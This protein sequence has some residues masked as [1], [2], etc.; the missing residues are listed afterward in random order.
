MAAADKSPDGHAGS[1]RGQH[2]TDAVLDHQCARRERAHFLR[3]VEK[4]IRRGLAVRDHLRR[5]DPVAEMGR[6]AGHP[7]RQ[8]DAVEITRRGHATRHAQSGQD[9]IRIGNRMERLLEGGQ[10]ARLQ[11]DGKIGRHRLA[12]FAIVLRDRARASSEKQL[13]RLRE[14]QRYPKSGQLVRQALA[15]QQLAVDEHAVAVEDDEIGPLPASVHPAIRSYTHA[16]SNSSPDGGHMR[17]LRG[18]W[19]TCR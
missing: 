13:E 14:C 9:G 10:Y 1:L 5:V 16:L 15:A 7:Q 11:P 19:A 4:E 3:R 17:V 8:R 12:E 18:Q 6:E 2:A